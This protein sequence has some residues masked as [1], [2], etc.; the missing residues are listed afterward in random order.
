MRSVRVYQSLC[1]HDNILNTIYIYK[2]QARHKLNCIEC[3][4]ALYVLIH[5]SRDV[6]T[7]SFSISLNISFTLAF[8]LHARPILLSKVFL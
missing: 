7:C 5:R 3:S 4:I 6:L 1:M 2:R 8:C